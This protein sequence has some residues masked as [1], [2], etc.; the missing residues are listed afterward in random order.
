MAAGASALFKSLAKRVHA[1][2]HVLGL[3]G[4]TLVTSGCAVFGC[5]CC[6]FNCLPQGHD[7]SCMQSAMQS[8]TVSMQACALERQPSHL[9]GPGWSS[10]CW[11]SATCQ[12]RPGPPGYEYCCLQDTVCCL[13]VHC[14][15]KVLQ[16][17]AAV[18]HRQL[19]LAAPMFAACCY[20][21][22]RLL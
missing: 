7:Q 20:A 8:A 2:C 3:Q 13:L 16:Y 10:C 17:A 21:Q 15:L 5:K 9:K 1:F 18:C 6:C 12:Q 4:M 11:M 19:H 22:E 14:T